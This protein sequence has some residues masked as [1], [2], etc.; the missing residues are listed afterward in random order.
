MDQ[1]A[2]VR[3]EGGVWERV[4]AAMRQAVRTFAGMVRKLEPGLVRSLTLTGAILTDS[5]EADR[6]PVT[7]VLVLERVDFKLLARLAERG[8]TLGKLGIAAPLI[9]TMEHLRTSLDTF[10][11]ELIEIQELHLTLFGD[12]PFTDLVFEAAHVRLQCERDLKRFLIGLRQ[13]LLTSAGR[14]SHLRN[15]ERD[16]AQ[17]LLRTLRGM[18]WLKGQRQFQTD[19]EVLVGVESAVDR[20][21]RGVRA[22]LELHARP[23]PGAGIE[24][25]YRDVEALKGT[26]ENW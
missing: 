3:N 14:E 22:S 8:S 2:T 19:E 4:P 15:V 12:D 16:V 24:E 11:L 7:S 23:A 10:P 17:G 25:L 18:L 20:A 9:L 5:F 1:T 21:L 13:G 26:V 6:R